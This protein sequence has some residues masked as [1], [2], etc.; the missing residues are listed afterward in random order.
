MKCSSIFLLLCIVNT[1]F[2]VTQ[3]VAEQEIDRTRTKFDDIN[4]IYRRAEKQLFLLNN[5]IV[6]LRYRYDKKYVPLHGKNPTVE[7]LLDQAQNEIIVADKIFDKATKQ[8]QLEL[9]KLGIGVQRYEASLYDDAYHMSRSVYMG[10]LVIEGDITTS[11]T[12]MSNASNDLDS[13]WIL[14]R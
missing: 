10:L 12:H 11:T 9:Q 4:I 1:G 8:S 14:I 2:A 5:R 6:Y 7:S 13:V 3:Q